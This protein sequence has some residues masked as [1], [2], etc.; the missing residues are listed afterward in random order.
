MLTDKQKR[1]CEEYV[2]DFNATQAAIRAGYSENTANEQASRMLA[3]V[4]IQEYV[5]ELKKKVADKLEV[6]AEYITSKLLELSE[7]CMQGTPVLD[8]DG[9]PTGEWKFEPHAAN[10]SLELLGKRIGYFEQDN[11]QK[12]VRIKINTPDE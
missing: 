2:V 9:N 8:K 7:R 3:N 11:R 6:S 10:K 12:G 4:N 5:S 1:F